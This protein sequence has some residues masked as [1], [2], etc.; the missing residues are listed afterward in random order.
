MEI[1][2]D[3]LVSSERLYHIPP[4]SAFGGALGSSNSGS[5]A[6]K[7]GECKES[8]EH[9]RAS[10]S[11]AIALLVT[12]AQAL[13]RD[14]RSR[15]RMLPADWFPDQATLTSSSSLESRSRPW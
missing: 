11:R 13:K 6:D 12:A 1:L 8:E 4:I 10:S 15:Q 7:V 9:E 2:E 14:A 5:E 3:S